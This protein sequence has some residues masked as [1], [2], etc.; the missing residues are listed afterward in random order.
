[1]PELD[2]DIFSG[3]DRCPVAVYKQYIKFRPEDMLEDESP[4]NSGISRNI[5]DDIWYSRQPMGNILY[6]TLLK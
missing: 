1:M 3:R 4:F 6:I 5:K 2:M